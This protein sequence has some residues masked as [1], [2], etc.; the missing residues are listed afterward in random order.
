MKNDGDLDTVQQNTPPDDR[1]PGPSPVPLGDPVVGALSRAPRPSTEPSS[2]AGPR[3]REDTSSDTDDVRVTSVM[4][5]AAERDRGAREIAVDPRFSSAATVPDPAIYL[6]DSPVPG[7]QT[8]R[9][10]SWHA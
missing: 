10:S 7:T 5:F 8:S 1:F 2:S 4:R 9:S 3:V 6:S